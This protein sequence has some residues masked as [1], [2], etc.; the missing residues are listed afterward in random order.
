MLCIYC[1][2]K[3]VVI[4]STTTTRANYSIVERFRKCTKCEHT[5]PTVEALKGSDY[6]EEYFKNTGITDDT[7]TKT[8]HTKATN[9]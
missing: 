4:G 9:S 1:A 5:F 8:T 2:S 6:W 3:T 7:Q